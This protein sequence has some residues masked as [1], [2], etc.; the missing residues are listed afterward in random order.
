MVILVYPMFSVRNCL[1]KDSNYVYLKNT[2]NEM[3]KQRPDWYFLYVFPIN[4]GWVY[5]EE[6]EFWGQKNIIRL[7]VNMPISK[8]DYVVHYD[9]NYWNKILKKYG[10]DIIWNNTVEVG[11]NLPFLVS[12]FDIKARPIVINQH[13]YVIHKSLPYPV[14]S[15]LNILY[16][17]LI[18]SQIVDINV[19]N[20]DYTKKLILDNV[21]E[22]WG[23]KFSMKDI[24]IKM[25]V[26]PKTLFEGHKVADKNEQ[27]TIH[28]NHRLQDFKKWKTTFELL[29]ELYKEG[30]DFKVVV[31]GEGKQASL[32]KYPF[33]E[34]KDNLFSY[35]SYIEEL[36]R[37]HLNTTN[38]TIETFCISAIESMGAGEIL[39]APNGL[40]FPELVPEGYP[41][42][43]NSIAEQKA[44]I[45]MFMDKWKTD[46]KD[47]L[48][49]GSELKERTLDVFSI[50]G[51][52]RRYIELFES[53]KFT[54]VESL[55]PQNR[56]HI[57]KTL[58]ANG[59]KFEKLKDIERM[60]LNDHFGKQAFPLIKIKRIL[61]DMGYKDVIL[62][63]EHYMK[64]EGVKK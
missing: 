15:Q 4:K 34:I 50:D 18:S 26:L 38:T 37:G 22:Y 60:L 36:S 14:E 58:K 62:D 23:D 64:F 29:G 32:N 19:F 24:I 20:S 59:V 1:N 61:N 51:Y 41:F 42:L 30:Y 40:T 2:I 43:Y 9:M 46:K 27:F 16:S 11:H 39:V 28:Y 5:E 56:Q 17:Q 44:L 54:M 13:H 49:M 63:G 6:P 45:K 55:K 33:V 21:G 8:R 57:I 47:Y 3:I 48:R 31:T 10:V 52:V 53:Y 35:E 12:T 25:G 7:D